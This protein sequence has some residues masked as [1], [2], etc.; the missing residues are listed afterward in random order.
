[1]PMKVAQ[2]IYTA[3]DAVR[4][5]ARISTGDELNGLGVYWEAA[6]RTSKSTTGTGFDCWVNYPCRLSALVLLRLDNG[7]AYASTLCRSW[8]AVSSHLPFVAHMR[9]DVIE[10]PLRPLLWHPHSSKPAESIRYRLDKFSRPPTLDLAIYILPPD[11]CPRVS[12]KT[13]KVK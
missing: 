8:G 1:M 13:N 3:G 10:H 5:W 2:R 7:L 4:P 6:F 9:R 11:P 12:K